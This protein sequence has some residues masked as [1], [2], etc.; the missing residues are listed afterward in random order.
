MG[1]GRLNYMHKLLSLTKV[2]SADLQCSYSTPKGGAL[3]TAPSGS[4]GHAPTVPP[5][6]FTKIPPGSKTPKV[7]PQH[8]QHLKCPLDN[9]FE[10]SI[11]FRSL[12]SL[13]FDFTYPFQ[14]RFPNPCK[15]KLQG[16]M[17][18]VFDIHHISIFILLSIQL[19][20]SY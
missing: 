14:F 9:I 8:F 6:K 12:F 18:F 5:S 7:P 19:A 20:F 2:A 1:P 13:H 10:V 17:F 11:T 4:P 16:S 15:L 3:S